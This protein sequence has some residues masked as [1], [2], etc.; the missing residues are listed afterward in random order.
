M[1]KQPVSVRVMAR[2]GAAAG[3]ANGAVGDVAVT[4]GVGRAAW[5]GARNRALDEEYLREQLGRLGNTPYELAERRAGYRRARP[6]RPSSLLNQHA[7]RSRGAVAG[8]AGRQ[9]ARR[10]CTRAA[11]PCRPSRRRREPADPAAC[12][13]WCARPRNSTQRIALRPASITLDYLDLYGLRP[14]LE[15]V[16]A[17]GIAAARGQSARPQAR[18]RTHRRFPAE[19]RLPDPGALRRP[20]C[21]PCATARITI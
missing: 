15:R 19:L 3:D 10:S 9:A 8:V 17:A 12:I 13:C 14:S 2:E 7:P 6:S 4:R 21:M 20:A 16:R 5:S 18:R 1:R 11:P